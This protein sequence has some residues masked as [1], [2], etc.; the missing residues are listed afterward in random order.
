MNTVNWGQCSLRKA[1]MDPP[2][3]TPPK[4][5]FPI[6]LLSFADPCPPWHHC[7]MRSEM[8]HTVPNRMTVL[9]SQH[10]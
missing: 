3:L 7:K 5:F 6:I 9:F 1:S 10:S 2:T 8:S 4:I